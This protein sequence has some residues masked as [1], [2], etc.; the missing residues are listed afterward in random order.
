MDI[1][2]T[3][4]T[5]VSNT[6]KRYPVAFVRGEGAHLWDDAGREYVDLGSGIAVNIFGVSD[7]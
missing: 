6:Y 3:C 4:E 7:P 2:K 5:Y 1:Q